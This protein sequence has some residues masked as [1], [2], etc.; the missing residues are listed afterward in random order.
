M[1]ISDSCRKVFLMV[2]FNYHCDVV[3]GGTGRWKNGPHFKK[4][5]KINF[6]FQHFH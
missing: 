3:K 6:M 1:I 4:V 2:L 5:I